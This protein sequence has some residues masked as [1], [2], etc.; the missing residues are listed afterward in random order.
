MKASAL[1]FRFR[2]LI[3]AAIFILGFSVPWDRWLHLDSSG[4]NAHVWGTLSAKLAMALPG[5]LSIGSAFNLLL[6]VG[7][8]CALVSAGLRTWGAAYLGATT[9][10]SASMHGTGSIAL[11]CRVCFLRYEHGLR[12]RRRGRRGGSRF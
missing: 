12:R 7:G 1:E 4:P 3:H 8:L 10:H 5:T 6:I 2:F 11:G 9:V